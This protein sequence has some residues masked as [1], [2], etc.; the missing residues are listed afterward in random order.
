[1]AD[2]KRIV[3]VPTS[4]AV[5]TYPVERIHGAWPWISILVGAVSLALGYVW[6]AF[7]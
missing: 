4:R 7:T 6:G 2:V 3:V 1:M 5:Y